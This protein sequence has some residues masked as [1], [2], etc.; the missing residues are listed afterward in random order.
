M[1]NTEDGIKKT[2]LENK[3]RNTITPG[4]IDVNIMTKLDKNNFT[5]EGTLIENG[6]D[7][8]SALRGY[9]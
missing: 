8:I 7:A 4:G 3:L 9:A 2:E 5:R 6:S 1:Q